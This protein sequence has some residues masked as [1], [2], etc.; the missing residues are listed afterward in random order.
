M[1]FSE[2]L[3]LADAESQIS[4]TL[5][6]ENIHGVCELSPGIVGKLAW[7]GSEKYLEAAAKSQASV[8]LVPSSLHGQIAKGQTVQN[9][10]AVFARVA[11]QFVPDDR[12]AIGVHPSAVIDPSATLGRNVR[13]GPQVTV[14]KGASLGDGVSLA[15]GVT[16]G[17]E[18]Q[19]GCDGRVGARTVIEARS[20]IGERVLVLPGAVIGSRGFGNYHDG[21]QWH[22]IP[23][24]GRVVVGDDVE[25]GA[26]TTIDCGALGDTIIADNVRIDNQCQIAHNVEIGPQTALAAQVGIAGSTKIGAGC[27]L[28]GQAGIAGHLRV[29]DRVILNGGTLVYQSIEE[30]GHYGSGVPLLPVGAFRRLV[31]LLRSLEP[32]F[33]RLEKAV[34]VGR[35][36]SG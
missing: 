19:I 11:A 22:E 7:C 34:K 27:M 29:A 5:A 28:G 24:M 30:S 17:P 33:R 8:I 15:A 21:S 36:Q 31:V 14:G 6:N 3:A 32:R 35:N 10:Q 2:L 23:Q 26:N 25:I 4:E 9:P 1:K 16:I 18:V 20:V 12:P 13:I